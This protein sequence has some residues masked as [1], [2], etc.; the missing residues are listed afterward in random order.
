MAK[1]LVV[2][3]TFPSSMND[4]QPRF[5]LDLCKA[6]GGEVEQRVVVP[7][8]QCLSKVTKIEGIDVHRFRYCLKSFEVLAYGGGILE[9]LKHNKL[10]WLLLPLFMVGM[11][12]EICLQLKRYKP[13]IIHAHWWLPAGL[14]S[15]I[16]IRLCGAK[17][18]LILTCHGGDYFAL[19][20]RFPSL[21]HWVF[22]KSD[23]VCMVSSV[24]MKDAISKGVPKGKLAVAPMGVDLKTKFSSTSNEQ[25]NG[26]LFVGRLAEKK[27]VEVLLQAWSLL[28][29]SIQAMGLN[30]VGKG[31]NELELKELSVSLGVSDTVIFEGAV[32]HELLP[33]YYRGSSLLVFPSIVSSDNDQEGLGLVPIE[34]IGCGCPVLASR[35]GPL[36]DVIEDKKS[37]YFFEMANA[38]DLAL[39]IEWFF[40]QDVFFVRSNCEFAQ[41]AVKLNYDWDHVAANHITIYTSL[42]A[43]NSVVGDSFN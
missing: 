11:V 39:K 19:G 25:R 15:L 14:A 7:S 38:R 26:V 27:G 28:P 9:N 5:V 37:G 43:G 41:R 34:A 31:V 1:V 40:E 2:A 21:M 33:D 22:S 42:T 35:I 20:Q 4:S 30:I 32:N 17:C 13:D 29:G 24:M 23:K 16:A 12:W 3:T 36:Y 8:A 6:L 18:K 10:K